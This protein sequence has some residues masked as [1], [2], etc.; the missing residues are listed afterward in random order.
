MSKYIIN[1]DNI[2]DID[3]YY[4]PAFINYYNIIIFIF[5]NNYQLSLEYLFY[6]I[7]YLFDYDYDKNKIIKFLTMFIDK[8]KESFN[9]TKLDLSSFILNDEL[10]NRIP[11]IINE[12]QNLTTIYF[13]P[14][15]EE[16]LTTIYF[17]QKNEEK[18]KTLIF[19]SK[20]IFIKTDTEIRP[21]LRPR[22]TSTHRSLSTPIPTPRQ[23]P[24]NPTPTPTPTPRR[25]L[26][27]T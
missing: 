17:N 26:I 5:D 25:T 24:A 19:K 14:K 10:I 12:L 15:N 7:N 18:L 8:Y 3:S 1:F 13:N 11:D 9:F 4:L 22:L 27:S 16:N 6:L 2:D 20:N 21:L 23:R